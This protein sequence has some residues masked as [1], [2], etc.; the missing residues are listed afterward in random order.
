MRSSDFYLKWNRDDLERRCIIS[1]KA[2]LW[3]KKMKAMLSGWQGKWTKR[4][5]RDRDGEKLKMCF[6]GQK[7]TLSGA[8]NIHKDQL[9]HAAR[10]L[11]SIPS[12]KKEKKERQPSSTPL[13]AA[14]TD[15][16]SIRR[17]DRLDRRRSIPPIK[18]PTPSTKKIKMGHGE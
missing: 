5:N 9:Q 12:L 17:T 10:T 18:K 13:S 7:N 15:Q 2:M 6:K 1:M 3:F 4:M 16:S 11:S 14:P 8:Q